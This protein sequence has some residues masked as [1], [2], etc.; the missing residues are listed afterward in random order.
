MNDKPLRLA[1]TEGLVHMLPFLFNYHPENSVVVAGLTPGGEL[2]GLVRTDLPADPAHWQAVAHDL[3]AHQQAGAAWAPFPT[4]RLVA[5]VCP[6]P[7]DPDCGAQSRRTHQPL[8]DHLREAC[9]HRGVVLREAVYVTRTHYWP[10]LAF[11][12]SDGHAIPAPTAELDASHLPRS[13]DVLES[14]RPATGLKAA[15]T[16]STLDA[17]V[18][19]LHAEIRSGGHQ[20]VVDDGID[21]LTGT[22][23]NLISTDSRAETLPDDVAAKLLLVLQYSDVENI[24]IVHCEDHEL[25]TAKDLWLTL[26]RFCPAS[27]TDLA[28]T[29]LALYGFT[30]WALGDDGTARLAL[31]AADHCVPGRPLT[32]F[33]LGLLNQGHTFTHLRQ[34][35]REHRA[36]RNIP[37]TG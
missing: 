28:G 6:D 34:H 30:A 16:T 10:M 9:H 19:T 11:G 27:Y 13:S 36:E 5:Y 32:E 8:V 2:V 25:A 22:V 31:Q 37:T 35:L 7:A 4:T 21:L 33:I 24:G 29:P 23:A 14:L 12:H 3:V 18:R 15:V 26:A 17:A 20:S 1:G